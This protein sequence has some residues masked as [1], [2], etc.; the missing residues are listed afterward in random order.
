ML[1]KAAELQPAD[2]TAQINLGMVLA[3]QND[4]DRAIEHFRKAVE[5]DPS[6]SAAK[7]N[8]AAALMLEGDRAAAEKLLAEISAGDPNDPFVQRASAMLAKLRPASTKP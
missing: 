5:L 6:N 7:Y 2:P 8:L 3:R 1:E 4:L